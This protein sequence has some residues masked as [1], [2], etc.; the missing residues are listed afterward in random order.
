[1]KSYPV[2]KHPDVLQYLSG[3]LLAL[4][5]TLL[6]F[7]LVGSWQN[8]LLQPINVILNKFLSGKDAVNKLPQWFSMGGI[9][10]LAVLQMMVHLRYF[11]HFGFSSRRRWNTLAFIFTLFIIV[12]MVGGTLWIMQDLKHQM[13]PPKL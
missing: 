4:L 7:G 11:L 12:F 13:L 1:M 2:E 3:F 10:I 9:I 8:E 5:L 6:A